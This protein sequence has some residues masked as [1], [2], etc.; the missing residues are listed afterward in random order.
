MFYAENDRVRQ[1]L[2]LHGALGQES[3]TVSLL[4]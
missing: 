4:Y 1:L 2:H 3:T